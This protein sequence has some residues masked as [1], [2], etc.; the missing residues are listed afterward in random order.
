MV[1]RDPSNN[2]ADLSKVP[3][4]QLE[5]LYLLGDDGQRTLQTFG[6]APRWQYDSGDRVKQSLSTLNMQD[7]FDIMYGRPWNP[8]ADSLG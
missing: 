3:I 7:V 5:P 2:L 1:Q 4:D 8:Q 6:L